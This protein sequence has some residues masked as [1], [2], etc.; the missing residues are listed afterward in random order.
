MATFT[1]ILLS[2]FFVLLN[3]FF[4][5][6]EFSIVKIRHTRVQTLEHQ[7]GIRGRILAKVH[8]QL[9]AYLSACQLGITL[10]SLGLGWIG[11]PAFAHLLLP[12]F[13]FL[14]IADPKLIS[15]F[16]FMAAFSIISYLH[17]VVGELMP[18]SM[19]IRQTELIA[20]WAVV[21]LY[22]FYW[23]MYPAIW[24]LN[25]SAN[26]FL[27][28]FKLDSA[29][30]ESFTYSP[31]EIKLILRTSH[32]YGEFT[33]SELDL[34]TKSLMFTDLEIADVMRPFT[35]VVALNIDSS[36]TENIR[37]MSHQRYSRYPVYKGD[38]TNFIGIVHIKDLFS[39]PQNILQ[40]KTLTPFIRPL[41]KVKDTDSVLE[42]FHLFRKGKPHFAVV[43]AEGKAVGFVTLDNLLQAIIGEIKDEFHITQEDWIMLKDGSFIIKGSA[44]IFTLETILGI[45][46]AE[47][48]G[49]TITGLI[50]ETLESFPTEGQ[51]IEFEEFSLEV[52]KIRGPRILQVRVYPKKKT[53]GLPP[54]D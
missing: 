12:L 8:G 37:K 27:K 16:S 39:V 48:K 17:I 41:L 47:V 21:P 53:E 26:I 18:K 34:L 19:A 10:A 29:H 9:D 28:W 49:N 14:E 23:L 25:A 30:K 35:E 22:L 32:R 42:V 7:R 40:T 38:L 31:E 6:A 54:E 2:F 1:L 15:F 45:D 43:F 4:V 11:E 51:K 13:D 50:L 36:V 46:L 33:K 20:L 5:A 52:R 3:G 44:P 24:V